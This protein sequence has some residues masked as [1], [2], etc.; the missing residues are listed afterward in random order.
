MARRMRPAG[1]AAGVLAA[2]AAGCGGPPQA[3]GVIVV[4]TPGAVS[5]KGEVWASTWATA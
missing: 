3:P 4:D 1:L 5:I 2:L